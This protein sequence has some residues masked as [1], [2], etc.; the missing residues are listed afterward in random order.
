MAA[1]GQRVQPITY[2]CDF[3]YI[4]DG[5][6]IVEDVKGVSTA[7]FR[8]KEKLFRYRYPQIELRIVKA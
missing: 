8:V 7:L 4:E 5:R 1:D 6:E 2:V 3:R